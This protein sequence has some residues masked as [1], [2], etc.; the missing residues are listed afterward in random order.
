[1]SLCRVGKGCLL[2]WSNYKRSPRRSRV[3]SLSRPS[4]IFSTKLCNKRTKV[5]IGHSSVKTNEKSVKDQIKT[6]LELCNPE[7]IVGL[8]R[9]LTGILLEI[10]SRNKFVN[11]CGLRRNNCCNEQWIIENYHPGICFNQ[12]IIKAVIILQKPAES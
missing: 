4:F 11:D 8:C 7:M 6:S 5:R 12:Q 1:M 10:F 2:P 9:E 3:S